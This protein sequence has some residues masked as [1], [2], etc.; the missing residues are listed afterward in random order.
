MAYSEVVK[1]FNRV[2]D[3]MREFYVYGFKSRDEYTKKS[4]RSYDDER[5]RLESWLGD[6]MQFRQNAEG[7]NVFLSIDSRSV[8]HNPLYKAW[9][10]K[11]FTD[12]DITLHFIL[13]DLLAECE[14]PVTLN[15]IADLVD[16]YLSV[17]DEP[18]TF[19]DS[20]IRKKL[21]E[22]EAEGI[23]VK[24]KRGKTVCY[25]LA[26]GQAFSDADVLDF[27]SEAA[28]CGVIGSF[29]LDKIDNPERDI[30]AFKHN[31]FSA[32]LDAEIMANVF[33]AMHKKKMLKIEYMPTYKDEPEN[34]R[35]I[36]LK[37]L[38]GSSTGRS[39]V[40]AKDMDK[41]WMNA[42]RLDYIMKIE[43]ME[44]CAE[45]V[46][47]KA[48][49]DENEKYL[50]GVSFGRNYPKTEKVSFTIK[51]DEEESFVAERLKRE[52]RNGTVTDLG[53][54]KFRYDAEVLDSNELLLWIRSFMGFITEVNISN[55][56]VEEH[57]K[58]SARAMLAEYG[59][60][61]K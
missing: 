3:Y 34:R 56:E 16:Q 15:E 24:E 58:E 59:V 61:Q 54:G 8:H 48:V 33:D 17:F 41:G 32:A 12:G 43:S 4:G 45:Y 60:K 46:A 42:Y 5:R 18:R 49:F 27:F 39:Y 23:I 52:K 20:T 22:Y 44:D 13:M 47:E 31:Y 37:I 11:S 57:F 9:K 53:D 28:P 50:W 25:A 1:N 2:R 19:D 55:K 51:I 29:A 35:I 14:E 40:A 36:P 10:A 30:F 38:I 26:T 6:Y 7:K 21:K